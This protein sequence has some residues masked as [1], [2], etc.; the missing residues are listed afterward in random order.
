[1]AATPIKADLKNTIPDTPG[2]FF[3]IRRMIADPDA[4]LY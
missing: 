1:M 2:N 4:V 3:G